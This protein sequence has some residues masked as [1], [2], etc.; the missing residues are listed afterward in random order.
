MNE[1]FTMLILKNYKPTHFL[2]DLDNVITDWETGMGEKWSDI[3]PEL[4]HYGHNR[5]YWE[6][7]DCYP[8]QYGDRICSI[9]E[10]PGFFRNLKP[11]P[12]AIEA[13]QVLREYGDIHFVSAPLSGERRTRCIIE[14][15]EWLEEYVWNNA[16]EL[17]FPTR[18]KTIVKGDYLFDD[19]PDIKGRYEPTW[20]HL[21][22]DDDYAYNKENN[23]TKINWK[24]Y[25]KVLNIND[26][27]I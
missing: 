6:I 8:A 13:L 27:K 23:A 14:K 15:C 12:G 5:P 9:F 16:S 24:N 7:R 11:I 3:V 25:K 1:N 26:F 18:D 10:E 22:F 17:L 21:L 4:E 2:I 20:K 19:R